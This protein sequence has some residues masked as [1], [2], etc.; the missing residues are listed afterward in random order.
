[1]GV[2]DAIQWACILCGHHI[3][4]DWVSNKSTSNF[5]FSLH[6]PLWKLLRWFRRP[7]V[8]ATGDWQLQHD[9]KHTQASCLMQFLFCETSNHP[10]D[11]APL[12]P[13]FGALWVLAVPKTKITFEGKR[14]QTTRELQENTTGQLIMTGRTVWGPKVP[15]LEETEASLSY[16]QCFL[17]LLQMSLFFPFY[18]AGYFLDRPHISGSS[19]NLVYGHLIYKSLLFLYVKGS[20]LFH[21]DPYLG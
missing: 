8:W 4:N 17:Y 18:V 10:G 6:I 2:V 7:T 1:M 20:H 19:I 3:Q 16:V 14:F 9:N 12:Q 11:S 5:V 21:D 15:T 13:R